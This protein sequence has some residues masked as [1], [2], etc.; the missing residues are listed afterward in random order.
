MASLAALRRCGISMRGIAMELGFECDHHGV[1]R[2]QTTA[3]R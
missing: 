2:E 1:N 3:A